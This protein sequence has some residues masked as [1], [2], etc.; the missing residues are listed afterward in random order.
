MKETFKQVQKILKGKKIMVS[1]DRYIT[2]EKLIEMAKEEGKKEAIEQLSAAIQFTP[3]TLKKWI[4]QAEERG[5]AVHHLGE[6]IDECCGSH[7]VSCKNYACCN[8]CEFYKKEEWEFDPKGNSIP[9]THF[10]GRK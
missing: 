4:K 9:G 5:I 2:V 10:G 7:G 3:E 6:N 8:H 1:R